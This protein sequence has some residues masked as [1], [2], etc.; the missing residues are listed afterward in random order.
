MEAVALVA[1]TIVLNSI[2]LITASITRKE[3]TFQH[4]CKVSYSYIAIDILCQEISG[5]IPMKWGCFGIK[6]ILKGF[7]DMCNNLH[8]HIPELNFHV[9]RKFLSTSICRILNDKIDILKTKY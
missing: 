4:G 8:G 6:N 3:K 1:S 5:R 7:F 2:V 9:L